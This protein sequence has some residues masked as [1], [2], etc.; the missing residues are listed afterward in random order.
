MCWRIISS[1]FLIVII[2]V[3]ILDVLYITLLQHRSLPE[4]LCLSP[5]SYHV[6]NLI[7]ASSKAMFASIMLGW[8]LRLIQQ[9]YVALDVFV[10]PN[11]HISI[12]RAIRR[13][14]R[15]VGLG[16]HSAFISQ[17]YDHPGMELTQGFIERLRTYIKLFI[18]L[19]AVI[20]LFSWF[21]I[22]AILFLSKNMWNS[23]ILASLL[24]LCILTNI[25]AAT[26]TFSTRL[27]GIVFSTSTTTDTTDTS[28]SVYLTSRNS[29]SSQ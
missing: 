20:A 5:I 14:K 1:F 2:V 3:E 27:K 9:I 25:V 17:T 21:E 16:F 18:F 28:T 10:L 4:V 8:C 19:H 12:T 29:I 24:E 23:L 7:K 26:W 22:F 15:K 6:R 13:K 11:R